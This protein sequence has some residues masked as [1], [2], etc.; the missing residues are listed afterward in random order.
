MITYEII[1]IDSS[2]EPFTISIPTFMQACRV[3]N[4]ISLDDSM[5]YSKELRSHDWSKHLAYRISKEE[6]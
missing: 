2:F 1:L 5:I 3:F 4:S 6:L